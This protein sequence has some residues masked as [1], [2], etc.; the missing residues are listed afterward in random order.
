MK[1]VV[2]NHMSLDGVIQSPARQDED[3]RNGFSHGGWAVAGGDPVMTEWI[4]PISSGG[5]WWDAP[6][7]PQLRGNAESLE[8]RG[9]TLQGRTECGA[10]VRR[11]E[12]RIYEARVAELHSAARRHPRCRCGAQT[13][14]RGSALD[15]GQRGAD[16][17]AAAA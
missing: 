17:L 4:G 6:R 16:P 5:S 12:Q 15:H 13:S 11:I 2:L 7:P 10:Q 3:T 14:G 9:R 8:S 1:L